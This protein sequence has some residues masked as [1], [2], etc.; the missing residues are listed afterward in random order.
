MGQSLEVAQY[1]TPKQAAG[2]LSADDSVQFGA[3]LVRISVKQ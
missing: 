1:S 2:L 3:A